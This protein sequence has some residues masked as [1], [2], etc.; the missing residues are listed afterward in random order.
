MA[1][2]QELEEW[3]NQVEP[4]ASELQGKLRSLQTDHQVQLLLSQAHAPKGMRPEGVENLQHWW[5]QA[6]DSLF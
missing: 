3:R 4:K 5:S 6:L 2:V 1:S